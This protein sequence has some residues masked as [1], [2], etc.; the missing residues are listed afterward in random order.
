MA[1]SQLRHGIS[2]GSKD[3]RATPTAFLMPR[4]PICVD[5]RCMLRTGQECVM[6]VLLPIDGVSFQFAHLLL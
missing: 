5:L 3:C 6:W 2:A 4:A 1:I